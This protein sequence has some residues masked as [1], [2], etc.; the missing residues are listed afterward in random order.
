MYT[1][2]VHV[3]VCVQTCVQVRV[4]VHVQVGLKLT[5]C[6]RSSLKGE[7]L[8]ESLWDGCQER[9]ESFPKFAIYLQ[10]VRGACD[11]SVLVTPLD[12]HEHR[13]H[14]VP[15]WGVNVILAVIQ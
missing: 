15:A 14:T 12:G 1:V 3:Q 6:Q 9:R 7:R 8:A 11:V 2:Q 5:S 13:L 4:Q 10:C